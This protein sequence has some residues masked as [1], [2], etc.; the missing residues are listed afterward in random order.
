MPRGGVFR[1]QVC[2]ELECG[3]SLAWGLTS[4]SRPGVAP[5]VETG[6][7]IVRY[8]L[9]QAETCLQT[10]ELGRALLHWVDD[11]VTEGLLGP[12]VDMLVAK[13]LLHPQERQSDYNRYHQYEKAVRTMRDFKACPPAEE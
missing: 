10:S 11:P 13:S 2:T 6:L 12:L 7:G 1:T 9:L 8:P 4:T 3:W 5:V